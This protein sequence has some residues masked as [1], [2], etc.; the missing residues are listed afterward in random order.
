MTSAFLFSKLLAA[1][2][3][4]KKTAIQ[5]G[6]R[7]RERERDKGERTLPVDENTSEIQMHTYQ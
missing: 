6:E 3:E 7:Q 1:V 5:L 2:N 4:G